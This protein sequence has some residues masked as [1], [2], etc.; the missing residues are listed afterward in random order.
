[1]S[2]LISRKQDLVLLLA[3]LLSFVSSHLLDQLDGLLLVKVGLVQSEHCLFKRDLVYLVAVNDLLGLGKDEGIVDLG[4]DLD[5]DVDGLT[6]THAFSVKHAEQDQVAVFFLGVLA[7]LVG[8]GVSSDLDR[9]G[10]SELGHALDLLDWHLDIFIDV[11][12]QT[13]ELDTWLVWPPGVVLQGDFGKDSVSGS[14]FNDVFTVFDDFASVEFPALSS[15][16]EGIWHVLGPVVVISG[17][18]FPSLVVWMVVMRTMTM[19]AT[20][21]PAMRVSAMMRRTVVRWAMMTV[22][23]L[24]VW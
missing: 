22:R 11:V 18:L 24:W 2:F 1:V 17:P 6:E 20:M 23:G 8:D 21:V 7:V 12:G 19:W 4:E 13:G 10:E 15:R 5:I 3:E 16:T 9:D 14:S